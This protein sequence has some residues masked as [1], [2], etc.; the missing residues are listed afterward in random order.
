MA[1]VTGVRR[2]S[3]G[4]WGVEVVTDAGER[5]RIAERRLL[6]LPLR[7]GDPL[8]DDRLDLLR[9]WERVDRAERQVLNLLAVRARSR[10]EVERRL[11]SRGLGESEV[12]EV[13]GRLEAAGLIDDRKLAGEVVAREV[14]AGAGRYRLRARLER[15]AVD[16]GDAEEAL[17]QATDRRSELERAQTLV[18]ARF[19]D[20]PMS[21][22]DRARAAGLLAR[23]GFDRDTVE[24]AVGTS[25]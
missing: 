10:A 12:A 2:A 15:L 11:Q 3:A 17:D 1:T 14:Q 6:D 20:A 18:R 9:G 5:L 4:R 25:D 8:D 16:E 13:C 22:R 21:D 23:R 24:A 19:G 7:S